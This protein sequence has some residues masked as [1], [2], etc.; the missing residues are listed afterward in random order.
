MFKH[1]CQCAASATSDFD[2]DLSLGQMQTPSSKLQNVEGGKNWDSLSQLTPAAILPL[3]QTT[4]AKI[5][6]SATPIHPI[7][8]DKITPAKK[9]F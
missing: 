9:L 3:A 2:P 4:S 7:N 6:S 8:L 5:G 1:M